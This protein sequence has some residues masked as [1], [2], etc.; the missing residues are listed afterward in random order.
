[1]LRRKKG[2]D[3]LLVSTPRFALGNIISLGD[4]KEL[5]RGWT[6]HI[7]RGGVENGGRGGE[8]GRDSTYL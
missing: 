1:L 6:R 4:E 8:K 7:D 3:I 2:G 5:R